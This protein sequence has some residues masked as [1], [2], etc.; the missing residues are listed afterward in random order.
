MNDWLTLTRLA[1]F[2][3]FNPNNIYPE[4]RK[5]G[6]HTNFQEK[7]ANKWYVSLFFNGM[8]P[9]FLNLSESLCTS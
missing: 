7:A 9:Y 1:K 5:I 6:T 2:L 3:K 8:C 4:N